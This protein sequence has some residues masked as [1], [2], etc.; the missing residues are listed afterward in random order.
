ML[1]L[2][3][4]PNESILIGDIKLTFSHNVNLTEHGMKFSVFKVSGATVRAND[5]AVISPDTSF[6]MQPNETFSIGEFTK[7]HVSK[8]KGRSIT[9]GIEAPRDIRILRSKLLSAA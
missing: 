5:G 9:I 4:T 6:A 7:A 2:S 1:V 8:F 3:L